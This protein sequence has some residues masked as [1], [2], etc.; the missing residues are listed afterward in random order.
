LGRFNRAGL[1]GGA[2][3]SLLGNFLLISLLLG[4][5][6]IRRILEVLTVY[7]LV[8]RQYV[9]LRALGLLCRDASPRSLV[10]FSRLADW[11]VIFNDGGTALPWGCDDGIGVDAICGLHY[12]IFLH[13]GG[14]LLGALE[15]LVPLD[16]G[17][18][19]VLVRLSLL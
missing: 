7:I 15:H 5:F 9:L 10:G 4:G 19:S 12:N 13:D 16:R 17:D 14:L 11:L 3:L 18:S 2:L 8:L 1:E 6:L